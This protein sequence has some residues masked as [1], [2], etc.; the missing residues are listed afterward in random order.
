M[1]V[2][3][4]GLGQIYNKKYWKVPLIYGG[5]AAL[6]YYGNSNNDYYV[7]FRDAYN[8]KKGTIEGTIPEEISQLDDQ[9]LVSWREKY[10]RSRDLCIIGLFGIYMLNIIDAN[11]DAYLFNFDVS[12][13][14][15]LRIEPMIFN[16]IE[17][18]NASV[19]I[20]CSI[21]F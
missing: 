15:S 5:V 18:N 21:T 13:D 12:D 9:A 11:V 4:P 16:N 17:L 2:V 6:V 1:S 7:I 10:R 14:L 3:I 19:G 8:I 20:K